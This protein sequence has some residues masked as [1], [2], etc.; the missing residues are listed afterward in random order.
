VVLAG[1]LAGYIGF[2][3]VQRQRFLSQLRI[4]RVT[5]AEL[6]RMLEAREPV[7]IVDLRH[8]LDFETDPSTLPGAIHFDP[9]EVDRLASKLSTDRD[10]ILYCT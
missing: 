7:Q 8:A 10:V 2:K 9:A 1:A 3:Y 5:P 4:A 6:Q